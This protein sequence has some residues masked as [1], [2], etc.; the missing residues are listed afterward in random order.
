MVHYLQNI[1]FSVLYLV[2]LTLLANCKK[3]WKTVIIIIIIIVQCKRCTSEK[4]NSR[5]EKF[6]CGNPSVEAKRNREQKKKILK[7]NAK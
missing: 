2:C 4:Y 1:F 6:N 3:E 7:I 5:K